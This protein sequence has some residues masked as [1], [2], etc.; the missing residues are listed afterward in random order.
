MHPLPASWVETK[1][2]H[3]VP[4]DA[5]L[6]HLPST[7]SHSALVYAVGPASLLTHGGS[8][9]DDKLSTVSTKI[10]FTAECCVGCHQG[11]SRR[12][13]NSLPKAE[14]NSGGKRQCNQ[15]CVFSTA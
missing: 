1:H 15:H 10:G 3:L 6:T 13:G 8:L 7:R 4:I 11:E 14:R 9:S 12:A 2:I 5:L